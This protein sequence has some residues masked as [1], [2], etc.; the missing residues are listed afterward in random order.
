VLFSVTTNYATFGGGANFGGVVGSKGNQIAGD[1]TGIEWFDTAAVKVGDLF[2][3]PDGGLTLRAQDITANP[4]NLNDTNFLWDRTIFQKGVYFTN[5]A[6]V[7]AS[8][9]NF[10]NATALYSFGSTL[11]FYLPNGIEFCYQGVLG[12]LAVV[13]E[14]GDV[15]ARRFVATA[16]P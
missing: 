3:R 15:K 11:N 4:A 10:K 6:D 14:I 8:G 12:R 2:G 5:D 13:N 1:N 7:A 9:V 16:T